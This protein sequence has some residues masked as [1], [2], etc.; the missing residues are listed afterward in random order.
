MTVIVIET[1]FPLSGN[2]SRRFAPFNRG[3]RSAACAAAFSNLIWNLPKNSSVF[4]WS[5]FYTKNDI[6]A[7]LEV[8]YQRIWN[9]MPGKCT[10]SYFLSL[11]PL[12]SLTL[13]RPEDRLR[14]WGLSHDMFYHVCTQKNSTFLLYWRLKINAIKTQC[15]VNILSLTFSLSLLPLPI[16][17]RPLDRLLT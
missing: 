11:S 4:I 2:V 10:C 14:T 3:A 12:F 5:H 16:L 8:E 1:Q 7:V 17:T 15:L 13:L 6:F 9:S